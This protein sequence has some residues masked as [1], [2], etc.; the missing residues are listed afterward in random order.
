MGDSTLDEINTAIYNFVGGV[1]V[2]SYGTYFPSTNRIAFSVTAD[3]ESIIRRFEELNKNT[4]KK[5]DL[6]AVSISLIG[7]RDVTKKYAP[8][9][10]Y[11]GNSIT[12]QGKSDSNVFAPVSLTYKVR[13]FTEKTTDLL[14]LMELWVLVIS[15]KRKIEYHSSI[16]NAEAA[17]EL[18]YEIPQFSTLPNVSER[19]GGR[20]AIYSFDVD[21]VADGILALGPSN[22]TQVKRILNLVATLSIQGKETDLLEITKNFYKDISPNADSSQEISTGVIL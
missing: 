19:W 8:R 13:V 4:T 6:P 16:L 2:G 20:G 7:I 14:K 11:L 5:V 15:Q 18:V 21:F 12:S 1:L 3:D 10:A 22:D 17:I 9:Y